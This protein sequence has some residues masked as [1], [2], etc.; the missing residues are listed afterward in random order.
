MEPLGTAKFIIN[1]LEV[2]GQVVESCFF[3][4]EGALFL[5]SQVDQID[6][7]NSLAAAR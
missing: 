6:T 3:S 7:N 1:F 2:G 4:A 5:A